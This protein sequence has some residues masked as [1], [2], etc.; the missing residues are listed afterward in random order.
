MGGRPGYR[1]TKQFD[2]STCQ[3][4][5]LFQIDYS[6]IEDSCKPRQRFMSTYEQRKEPTDRKYQYILFH[7]E[8]Y[9]VIAFKVPSCELD[10][11]DSNRWIESHHGSLSDEIAGK[12]KT[13]AY[14]DP[15]TKIYT[16][17]IYFKAPK[18]K[19][20]PPLLCPNIEAM[21]PSLLL[22]TSSFQ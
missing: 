2:T 1:V 5:I 21:Q 18:E 4:S 11:N 10:R 3:R 12:D 7:A 22:P 8:P 13:F 15:D 6:E 17:Q 14:W 16:L 9:E 19:V 20:R